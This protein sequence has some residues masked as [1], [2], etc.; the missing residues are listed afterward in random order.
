MSDIAGERFTG[1]RSRDLEAVDLRRKTV[2]PIEERQP[3]ESKLTGF[4][5]TDDGRDNTP[6]QG[7]AMEGR[8]LHPLGDVALRMEGRHDFA[9]SRSC[10]LLRALLKVRNNLPEFVAA[11]PEFLEQRIALAL[12]RRVQLRAI[13][14]QPLGWLQQIAHPQLLVAQGATQRRQLLLADEFAQLALGIVLRILEVPRSS[15]EHL[16]QTLLMLL[17]R[18]FGQLCVGG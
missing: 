13:A 10:D 16:V 12:P 8:Q 17:E 3:E 18:P 7:R 15:I 1:M 5:W 9:D 11:D 2:G 6:R 14:I 4:A